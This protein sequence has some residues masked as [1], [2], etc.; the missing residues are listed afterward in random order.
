MARHEGTP[1]RRRGLAPPLVFLAVLASAIAP[2]SSAHAD[3]IELHQVPNEF[4]VDD[5]SNFVRVLLTNDRARQGLRLQIDF[6][7]TVF[8]LVGLEPGDR[9]SPPLELLHGTSPDSTVHALVLDR[10]VARSALAP[11]DGEILALRFAVVA[12][13]RADSSV[14]SL[15]EAE[16]AD[17]TLVPQPVAP[18]Q[19][20]VHIKQPTIV[21]APPIP[22]RFGMSAPRPNPTTG[23]TSMTLDVPRREHITLRV[24]DVTG[25]LIAVPLDAWL[26][27]G[28]H[29]VSWNGGDRAGRR[30]AAGLYFCRMVAGPLEFTQRLVIAR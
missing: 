19:L 23:A 4:S 6:D 2:Q 29:S 30:A 20:M 13:C 18:T 26:S 28:R 15:R 16:T 22:V 3:M 17:A 7:P 27:G 9:V 11:G 10:S 24:Y 8:Q 1:Q 12:G 5:S 14:V 21:A 25:R